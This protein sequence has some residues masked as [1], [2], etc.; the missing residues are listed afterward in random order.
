[1]K[2]LLFFAFFALATTS[3]AACKKKIDNSKIMMFVDVN[4]SDMEIDTAEKAACERGQKLVVIPKDYKKYTALAEKTAKLT[5]ERDRVNKKNENVEGKSDAQI[6]KLIK[7]ANEVER[8]LQQANLEKDELLSKQPSFK[9]QIIEAL[10]SFRANKATIENFIISGHDGGGTYSGFKGS[11]SRDG[12]GDLLKD[13]SDVNQAK[14]VL[15]LGCYTGVPKEILDW[16]KIFPDV[17]LIGGYDGSAPLSMRPEGHSYLY[18]LLM[19]E[20]Q[21]IS[22][23]NIKKIQSVLDK[24]FKSLKNLQASMYIRPVC[25]NVEEETSF[26][27]GAET[28]RSEDKPNENIKKSLRVFSLDEC[29]KGRDKV[30]E[31]ESKLAKYYSG[32][33]EPPAN[34]ATGELRGMYNIARRFEHCSELGISPNATRAFGLLF[35]DGMKKSFASFYKKDLENVQKA[36]D[37]FEQK[38]LDKTYADTIKAAEGHEEANKRLTEEYDSFRNNFYQNVDEEQKKENEARESYKRFVSNPKNSEFF[39]R[40]PHLA[41][42]YKI[43]PGVWS[44]A[45]AEDIATFHELFGRIMKI[46]E[47]E[48]NLKDIETNSKLKLEAIQNEQAKHIFM[49]IKSRNTAEFFRIKIDDYKKKIWV[50]TAENLAGK[51]RKEIL[52]NLHRINELVSK[53]DALPKKQQ[54]ALR[55]LLSAGQNHL[56][57][58]A[59]PFSWHELASQVETPQKAERFLDPDQ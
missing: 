13:Y 25:Q 50:P 48:S 30:L 24:N 15:L 41:S 17:A 37:E 4:Q 42:D 55:W 33:L 34:T 59:S 46:K 2:T 3:Q 29:A 38:D 8:R 11:V 47:K 51:T 9:D 22:S 32:E 18:D 5:Q 43:H 52:S 53:G 35:Y 10:D 1:M 57:Y 12:I 49:A 36:L 19:K 14:S 16:K 7:E 58:V 44:D 45:S 26:Y 39:K 6:A 28:S 21:L 40:F 31:M 56:N 23:S 27:Y 54:T 20:K